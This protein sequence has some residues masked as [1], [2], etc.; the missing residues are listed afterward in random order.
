[1]FLTSVLLK[2]QLKYLILALF[3]KSWFD[4]I[5]VYVPILKD[6]TTNRGVHFCYNALGVVFVTFYMVV[7]KTHIYGV[8]IR[9]YI[10]FP[11]TWTG[12]TTIFYVY[13]SMMTNSAGTGPQPILYAT[14]VTINAPIVYT[15]LLLNINTSKNG[16]NSKFS[17]NM[18]IKSIDYE[19][20]TVYRIPDELSAH[21]CFSC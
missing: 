12:L 10:F 2:P 11:C 18:V 13:V 16:N 9:I 14:T 4:C 21:F 3:R 17:R 15:Y 5:V 6:F 1:M 20:F 8:W 7:N 19:Q